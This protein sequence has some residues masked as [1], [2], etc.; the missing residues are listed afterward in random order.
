MLFRQVHLDFHTPELPFQLGKNFDKQQF[1]AA[2]QMGHVNSMTLC[3]RDHHGHIFYDTT[4][5]ARHPQMKGDFLMQEVD[6]CH[7][8][9]VRCPLYATVGWDAY[10]AKQHPEWLERKVDGGLY[11][12]DEVGQLG[13]GWRTLCFNTGYVD[14]LKTQVTDMLAHFKGKVDGV[15]FDIIRQDECFCDQCIQKMQAQGLDPTSHADRLAFATA[16]KQTFKHEMTAMIHAILPDCP[17][18]YNEGNITPAIRPNLADYDHLEIESLASADWGYQ[19]FPVTVR[20]A[21]KLG[22]PY[23]GMTGKFQR[24]W[25]DFGSLKNLA[26]LEYECFLPI[27]HGAGCSIGD[28]MY[29][30]GT[31][32]LATYKEIGQVYGVIEQLEPY[33]HDQESTAD[34]AVMH[35][36]LYHKPK[37]K[38]DPSLAGVT[39]MLNEAH[40]MFDIVD[41]EMSLD[42]YRVVILPDMVRL[43]PPLADKLKAYVTAGGKLLLTYHS[44][45][46]RDSDQFAPFLGLE[47]RGEDAFHP[48]YAKFDPAL[49][50]ADLGKAELVLHG[51]AYNVQ[52]AGQPIGTRFNPM[53]NRTFAHYY[54]H[55]QAP[56]S[57]Q[58][59]YPFGLATANVAYIGSDLFAM[60]KEF[61]V[62][63]YREIVLYALTKVLGYQR[64][65]M[66]DAPITADVVVNRVPAQHDYLIH[67]MHYIPV[68]RAKRLDTIEAATPVTNTHF[69]LK[70]ATGQAVQAVKT[71][72]GGV[73]LPY[74]VTDE[75]MVAF[76]LPELDNYEVIQV[77]TDDK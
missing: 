39:N 40:L 61:G 27:A 55:Y 60:Y 47:A 45:L 34:I 28:Q 43:T 59:R 41:A 19:H 20:Y 21:K 38:V 51:N 49:A 33:I 22:V 50:G 46:M 58:S 69:A 17:I 7:E 70:L 14:Y 5:A 1:Q 16:T 32:Q 72:R 68:R 31:L 24:N 64:R 29:P 3:A 71:L 15:F 10:A 67:Y 76:T 66:T 77:I 73:Q 8:I 9:G 53:Y 74:T 4:L 63:E 37:A 48:T 18:F 30:D 75:G 36:A 2:L 62:R 65:L 26:A 52:G 44:G 25:A 6:A 54:S 23:I 12:F 35:T 42:E 56:I 57:G 13:P 11:G